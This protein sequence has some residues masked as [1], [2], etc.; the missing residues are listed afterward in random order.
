MSRRYLM[1]PYKYI[2]LV[3]SALLLS[4][5]GTAIFIN[6]IK[7]SR[8]T[9]YK[10][11]NK[12]IMVL[13]ELKGYLYAG[14]WNDAKGCQ[15]WRTKTGTDWLPVVT[16]GF[17]N[18]RNVE[19][20]CLEL[21]KNYLYAGGRNLKTGAYLY[22]S[23]DGV[24]WKP[25]VTDGFRNAKNIDIASL[26]QFK[27]CLYAGTYNMDFAELWR[28]SDGMTWVKVNIDI[29]TNENNIK[30]IYCL[31]T[32]DGY[33]YFGPK[34]EPAIAYIYRSKN[35]IDWEKVNISTT[36]FTAYNCI[37]KFKDYIYAGTKSSIHEKCGGIIRTSGG[38]N[39]D[40]IENLPR[41]DQ[42]K[43]DC[44]AVFKDEL[45]SGIR[46][47]SESGKE[48]IEIWK[49][50]DGLSWK[51]VNSKMYA[52]PNN[53]LIDCMF[54]FKGYIYVGVWNKKE[55]AQIWRTEK[56]KNWQRVF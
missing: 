47:L 52:N 56:L 35:G 25:V 49:S 32:D 23:S 27:G 8:D 31:F 5:V 28:S 30:V 26:R 29:L 21:F 43:V 33:L 14:T 19:L 39:W 15:L 22:R 38:K 16:N 6:Y 42:L 50:N 24:I 20:F 41:K 13:A 36:F 45:Y 12:G 2:I 55:G 37:I 34:T 11:D 17:G 44:Q 51:S 4:F 10:A 46:Y 7:Y 40:E 54:E 48:K 1:K 9:H 53:T 3:I 18:L